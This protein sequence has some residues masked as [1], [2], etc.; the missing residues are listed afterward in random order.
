MSRVPDAAL[1]DVWR[2]GFAVVEG[3]LGEAELTAA[4]AALPQLLPSAAQY[5]RSPARYEHLVADQFA[6]NLKYP[7]GLLALD[8]LAYHPDLIDAAERFF[9][10]ADLAVYKVELWGKYSGAVDYDQPP[11]RDYGNHTLLVPRADRRWTQLTTWVL[12]SDVTEQDGPTRVVPR[13]VGDR[14]PLS[15]RYDRDAPGLRNA[16]IPVVGPAGTLFLYTTDVFHRGS[17][18]TGS[19]RARFTYG[20]DIMERGASWLGKIAWPDRALQVGWNEILGDC[21][22]RQ[23]ELFGIPPPGHGFW[24]EQTIRDAAKRWPAWDLTPYAAAL[25]SN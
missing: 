5:H 21:T 14:V 10:S 6:G 22:P 18:M 17:A 12:L 3:F 4:Q 8:R 20:V 23:C 24:N 2:Q 19:K 9:E 15:E 16:E 13:E 25:P 1:D 11:H 7:F